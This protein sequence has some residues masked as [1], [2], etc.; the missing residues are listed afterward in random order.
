MRQIQHAQTDLETGNI[1]GQSATIARAASD[2]MDAGFN[3]CM[4][5]QGDPYRFSLESG[6]ALMDCGSMQ[7]W[8]LKQTE[9]GPPTFLDETVCR[10]L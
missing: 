6:S 10:A 3:Y 2:A 5:I 9:T 1:R 8:K 7:G 4:A